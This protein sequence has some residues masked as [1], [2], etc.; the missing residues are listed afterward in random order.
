MGEVAIKHSISGHRADRD[1][2]KVQPMGMDKERH[3]SETPEGT[4]HGRQ[5]LFR[6]SGL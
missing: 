3:C 1:T 5:L 2:A 4:S 6:L